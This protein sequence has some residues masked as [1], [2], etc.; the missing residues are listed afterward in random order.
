[1]PV[2]GFLISSSLEEYGR[3]LAAFREG[4]RETDYVEGLAISST[5]E[6]APKRLELMRELVPEPDV[7]LLVNGVVCG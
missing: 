4:L 2:I 1:M 6:V 5:F 7:A 3:D